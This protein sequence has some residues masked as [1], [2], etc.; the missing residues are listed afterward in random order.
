MYPFS[1]LHF[2]SPVQVCSIASST[3]VSH[4]LQ[5]KTEVKGILHRTKTSVKSSRDLQGSK[6]CHPQISLW[7]MDYFKLETVRALKTFTFPLTLKKKKI[8][9]RACSKTIIRDIYEEYGLCVVEGNLRCCLEVRVR[10]VPLS[11]N[12]PANI[13]LPNFCFSISKSIAFLPFEVSNH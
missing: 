9:Q 11:L 10:C 13:Y 8:R 3:A 6:T 12:G 5:L 1:P 4:L 7:H 2:L